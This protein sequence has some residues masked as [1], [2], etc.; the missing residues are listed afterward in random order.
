MNLDGGLLKSRPSAVFRIENRA[1][2]ER[3][4]PGLGSGDA[5]PAVLRLETF[6]N[7]AKGPEVR[8]FVEVRPQILKKIF[9]RYIQ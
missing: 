9:R 7:P 6:P 4:K 2:Y 1:A 5:R 3:F 8:S